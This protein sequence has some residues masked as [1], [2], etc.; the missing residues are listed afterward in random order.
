MTKHLPDS[1][2]LLEEK[3][4]TSGRGDAYCGCGGA[5]DLL[6]AL[7]VYLT[8]LDDG[9]FGGCG[10]CDGGVGEVKGG[11]W[12]VRGFLKE[13]VRVDEGDGYRASEECAGR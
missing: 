1:V 4:G 7:E 3:V 5:Y 13:G 10:G 9:C 8:G 12:E 11:R 6:V 2:F